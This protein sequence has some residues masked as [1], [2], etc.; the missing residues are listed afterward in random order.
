MCTVHDR[1]VIKSTESSSSTKHLLVIWWVTFVCYH[2]S[3]KKHTFLER[4]LLPSL[5][6]LIPFFPSRPYCTDL[7]SQCCWQ[8]HV[9]EKIRRQHQLANNLWIK[10]FLWAHF[11]IQILEFRSSRDNQLVPYVPFIFWNVLMHE[12]EVTRNGILSW[13]RF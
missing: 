13:F 5:L 12:F 9:W 10:K 2:P 7:S 6:K 3:G 4:K 8:K 11:K 1:L